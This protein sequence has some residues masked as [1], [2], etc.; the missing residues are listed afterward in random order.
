M[1]K[2]VFVTNI[3]LM[4]FTVLAMFWNYFQASAVYKMFTNDGGIETVDFKLVTIE[5]TGMAGGI[6]NVYNYPV[7][8]LGFIMIVN[9]YFF[10]SSK[11]YVDVEKAM[12][13]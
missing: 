12:D 11:C 7:F 10:I 5:F 8:I 4:I 9:I 2:K 1:T 6:Q 13:I 3:T